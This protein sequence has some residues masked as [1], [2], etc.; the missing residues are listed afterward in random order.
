AA[1]PSSFHFIADSTF[2]NLQNAV[3]Q[4]KI[5]QATGYP[6]TGVFWIP[7]YPNL[8][9]KNL[10]VVYVATFG[11]R[12]NCLNFLKNYGTV[13]PNAYCAFASQDPKAPTARLSF[14]EV[15]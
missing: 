9:D 6:Q 5:L 14:K 12:S 2:P 3:K 1:L 8:V 10:F 15:Q 7:D 11:D 4:T 13:N